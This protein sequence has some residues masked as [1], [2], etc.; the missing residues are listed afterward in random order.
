MI[1][2]F[3]SRKKLSKQTQCLVWMRACIIA[4][5][6]HRVSTIPAPGQEKTL[7]CV[8]LAFSSPVHPAPRALSPSRGDDWA[9]AAAQARSQVFVG[10]FAGDEDL[11]GM[12]APFAPLLL[13]ET[14]SPN[15]NLSYL[16]I[17]IRI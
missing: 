7:Y 9:T 2:S 10:P 12:P 6:R 3:F 5:P 17:C 8:H 4:K 15:P 1:L 16:V 11:P 14:E 13:C